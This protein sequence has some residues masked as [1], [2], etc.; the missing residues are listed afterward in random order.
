MNQELA[1][2][3][4][5]EMGTDWDLELASQHALR[6]LAIAPTGRINQTRRNIESSGVQLAFRMIR[7]GLAAGLV[8]L[9]ER[10]K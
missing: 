10:T 3:L 9:P 2:A 8:V 5:E 7:A 6:N 4:R 1:R